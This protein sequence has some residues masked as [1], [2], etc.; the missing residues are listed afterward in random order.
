MKTEY[1]YKY[2]DNT[3][4][5]EETFFNLLWPYHAVSF[6]YLYNVCYVDI[7]IYICILLLMINFGYS[8]GPLV[9]LLPKH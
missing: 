5:Q 8:V 4:V 3:L 6:V 1:V 9:L 7:Q 2:Y